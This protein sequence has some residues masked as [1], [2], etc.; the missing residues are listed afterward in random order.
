[1][2]AVQVL[3]LL[4]ATAVYWFIRNKFKAQNLWSD[5]AAILIAIAI[6]TTGSAVL[7]TLKKSIST[8]LSAL[9]I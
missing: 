7:P 1:M 3:V 8:H 5:T 4:V 9:K 2:G 6:I